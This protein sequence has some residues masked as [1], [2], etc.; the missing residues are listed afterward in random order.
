MGIWKSH[1]KNLTK[2]EI[3]EDLLRVYDNHKHINRELY[4]EHGKYSYKS[5]VK[6]FGSFTNALKENDINKKVS[7]LQNKASKNDLLEDIIHVYDKIG[8]INEDIYLLEGK[9]TM[10]VVKKYFNRFNDALDEIR[11]NQI[12]NINKKEAAKL[13]INN[14]LID[15]KYK[16]SIPLDELAKDLIDVIQSN[17][18]LNYKILRANGKYKEHFYLSRFGSYERISKLLNVIYM[19]N[20]S[21]SFVGKYCIYLISEI[22]NSNPEYEKTFDWLIND[23]TKVK[24]RIDGY[25]SEYNLAVEYN[26]IQHYQH[27]KKLDKNYSD[28]LNRQHKDNIKRRLISKNNIQLLE[29]KYDEPLE[30]DYLKNKLIEIGIL[31]I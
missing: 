1:Y 8:H 15:P 17:L 30:R 20:D 25:F 7:Y 16:K 4:I 13:L 31:N 21:N 24:L 26:G 27:F 9:F 6:K 18:N 12:N 2:Q 22:L 14:S 10:F 29:I 11:S 23:R 19:K 28:F 5:I 3:S